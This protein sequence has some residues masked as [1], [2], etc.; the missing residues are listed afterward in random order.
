MSVVKACPPETLSKG[1]REEMMPEFTGADLVET[2]TLWHYGLAQWVE[3]DT[4]GC[5]G[6]VVRVSSLGVLGTYPWIDRGGFTGY[7]PHFGVMVRLWPRTGQGLKKIQ[8]EVLP[9]AAA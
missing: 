5:E 2:P 8:E 3:C 4:P 7:P 9:L 6:G 1:C